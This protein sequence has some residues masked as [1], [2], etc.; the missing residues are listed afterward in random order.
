MA[1]GADGAYGG[2]M[3]IIERVAR[4]LYNR[5]PQTL[6]IF[7]RD[8]A[9]PNSMPLSISGDVPWEEVQGSERTDYLNA[10]FAVLE[11]IREPSEAMAEAG[12]SAVDIGGGVIPTWQAMIDAALSEQ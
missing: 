1:V 2:G 4:A 12:L 7:I 9:D 5:K 10:A 6:D 8:C 11:A 3:S